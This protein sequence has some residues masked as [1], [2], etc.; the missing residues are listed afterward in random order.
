MTTT[1]YEQELGRLR[2]TDPVAYAIL[3]GFKM[4][5][6]AVEQVAEAVKSNN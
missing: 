3:L 2:E 1:Q 5:A 4:L 6:D